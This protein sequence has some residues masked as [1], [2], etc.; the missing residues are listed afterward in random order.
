MTCNSTPPDPPPPSLHPPPPL[1]TSRDVLVRARAL[2]F[3]GP[4]ASFLPLP[5]YAD[6]QA[7]I[8]YDVIH[9]FIRIALSV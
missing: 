6:V 5:G 1:A 9:S 3:S 2:F 4:V 7:P 8:L